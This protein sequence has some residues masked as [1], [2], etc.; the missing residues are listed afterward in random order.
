MK[1]NNM[2]KTISIIILP[3]YFILL[4][5]SCLFYPL[6]LVSA[7]E[8]AL[9]KYENNQNRDPFILLVT[10]DGKFT[11]TYGTI[12]SIDDV[13]LEGILYDENGKSVVVMNDLVLKEHDKIGKIQ[14]K[15]IE[16]DRVILFYKGEDHT[17][18]LKE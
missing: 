1:P 10:K 3:V 16:K 12:D 18:K 13:I 6:S 17:F 5:L 8:E 4:T 11:V 9:F 15:K 14:V 2:K 7:Q